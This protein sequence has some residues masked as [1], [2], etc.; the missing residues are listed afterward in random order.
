MRTLDGDRAAGAPPAAVVAVT[1]EA[2]RDHPVAADRPAAGVAR[3]GDRATGEVPD[4]LGGHAGGDPG[5]HTAADAGR[6]VHRATSRTGAVVARRNRPTA[7]TTTARPR[8]SRTTEP[9]SAADTAFAR[10]IC[11]AGSSRSPGAGPALAPPA[12]AA[13]VTRTLRPS[14]TPSCWAALMTPEAA[15]ASAGSTPARAPPVSGARAEPIPSPSSTSGST[16]PGKNGV[17]TSSRLSHAIPTRATDTPPI[18]S[19]ASPH[20]ADM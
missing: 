11:A 3:R 19:R 13:T 4:V 12:P 14:D 8:A 20:R 16:M 10:S 7:A 18:S 6:G 15:P 9:V 17:P 5:G 1:A 2:G